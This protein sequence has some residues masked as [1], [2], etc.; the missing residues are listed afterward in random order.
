[1][2]D[3]RPQLTKSQAINN[4]WTIAYHRLVYAKEHNKPCRC[5]DCREHLAAMKEEIPPR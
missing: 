4:Q 2:S 1:M 3:E 5:V